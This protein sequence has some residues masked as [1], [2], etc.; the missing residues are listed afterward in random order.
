MWY[1]R[2]EEREEIALKSSSAVAH[3]HYAYVSLMYF[4]DVM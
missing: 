3:K 1:A 2:L 4:D